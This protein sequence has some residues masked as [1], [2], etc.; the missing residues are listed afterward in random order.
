MSDA[1]TFWLQLFVPLYNELDRG[2]LPCLM[3]LLDRYV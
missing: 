1:E 3:Q 2:S